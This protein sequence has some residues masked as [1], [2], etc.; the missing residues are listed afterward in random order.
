MV[1]Q[2]LQKLEAFSFGR[3]FEKDKMTEV[4]K[5]E[6]KA[7]YDISAG[8]VAGIHSATHTVI[9]KPHK[10]HQRRQLDLPKSPPMQA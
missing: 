8:S 10:C 3:S 2:Y 1:K 7:K 6:N 4:N 9:R 5:E